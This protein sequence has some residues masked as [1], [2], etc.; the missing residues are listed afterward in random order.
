MKCQAGDI[1]LPLCQGE[2][3]LHVE[4]VVLHFGCS[5][6][7]IRP[8]GRCPFELCKFPRLCYLFYGL[9]YLFV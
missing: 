5:Y 4:R 3:M 6:G 2:C 7:V 1:A 9:W 8:S